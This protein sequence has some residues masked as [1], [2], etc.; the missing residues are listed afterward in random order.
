[1]VYRQPQHFIILVEYLIWQDAARRTLEGMFKGRKDVLAS[2]DNAGG[3]RGQGGDGRKGTGGSGGGGGWK[4]PN[5]GELGGRFGR[6]A[7]GAGKALM[8]ILAFVG[9]LSSRPSIC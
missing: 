4:P 7:G 1:M 5:W 9:R 3:G 8:A 2:F 6:G